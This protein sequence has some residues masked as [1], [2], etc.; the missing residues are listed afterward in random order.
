[1]SKAMRFFTAIAVRGRRVVDWSPGG[2]LPIALPAAIG[3]LALLLRLYGL[4]DKP[5]WLDEVTSLHRATA[6]IPDLVA[7]SLHNNHY[8]SYFLL[9]WLVAKIG[10]SQWLLRL[11]SALFGALAAALACAI[12]R[13]VADAR[14]GAVAGLLMAFSPFEVQFGQEARSY[15][16]VACL[17]LTALWGLVRLAQQPGAAALP[18]GREGALRGAWAA[19]GLGTAAALDV[20]NVAIPWF[21]AANLGAIVIARAAGNRQRGFWRNWGVAQ[22]LILA[23]WAP[24]LAAVYVASKGAVLDGVA[25]APAAT[26]KT[27]WAIVAPVYLLRLSNFITLDLAP[28]VVP[29]LSF[30]VT[31]LAAL[32]AWRLR[33]APTVLAALGCAALVLPLGLCLVSLFVPVLVPRY[34]AW[35]AAPFFIFAGAGLGLLSGA[36]FAALAAALGAICLINL[37]PYYRYETKPRW[38]LVAT[39]LAATAHSGDVVLVNSYYAYSVLAVFAARAGLDQRHVKLTWL[40]PEA[41]KAAPGHDVW[42][43]YGRSGQGAKKRSSG[44]YRRSLSLALGGPVAVNAIGRYIVLWRFKAPKPPEPEAEAGGYCRLEEQ[45]R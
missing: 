26:G 19:Y 1:M 17:I 22:L 5:F 15:T 42:A 14:A 40:L 4:G 21:V 11:P 2:G 45:R 44:D 28:A 34:F 20:L 13:R 31:A 32:G 23:A 35:S 3:A 24:L 30:G 16:L 29:G 8:P 37:I 38:D 27:I 10:A 39:R 12:G 6:R 36:R 43:V 18:F 33:R 41:A 7:D 25:W 9:L